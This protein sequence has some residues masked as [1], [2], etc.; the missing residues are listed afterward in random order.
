[1]R[2]PA[3]EPGVYFNVPAE[4]Y[5]SWPYASKSRM[6]G[7]RKSPA[8]VHAPHKESDSLDWGTWFHAAVLEPGL[9]AEKAVECQKLNRSTKEWKEIA[10]KNQGKWLIQADDWA[11]IQ[12]AA[13][14]V[15]KH[16]IA[17]PLVRGKGRNEAS[18]VFDDPDTGVRCKVRADRITAAGIVD[19]KTTRSAHWSDFQGDAARYGYF[20]Q[21]AMY[22]RAVKLRYGKEMPFIVVAVESE[23]V[24]GVNAFALE[25]L[26]SERELDTHLRAWAACKAA[27]KWPAYP[28]ILFNLPEPLW[29]SR[30]FTPDRSEQPID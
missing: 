24:H 26:E 13:S 19:I 21:A 17:G 8:H 18:M 20:L 16:K 15:L 1:M 2:T 14:R 5:H 27:D 6:I 12:T 30:L 11:S 7:F 4:D 22:R 10:A 28:E 23:G 25:C 9:F 3:P 29:Y